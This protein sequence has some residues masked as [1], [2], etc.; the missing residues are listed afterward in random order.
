MEPVQ[1]V[2]GCTTG[3]LALALAVYASFT[4]RR[5]GP[6]LSNTYLFLSREE[7]SRADKNAE[8]RLVTVVFGGLSLLFALFSLYIFTLWTWPFV[9]L[10]IVL[11]LVLGYA[12]ADA[13]RTQR[14]HRE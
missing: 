6:I 10:W 9:L 1:I 5:K 3:A 8:Y 13:V 4:A 2:F 14:K 7:R 12:I 11:A